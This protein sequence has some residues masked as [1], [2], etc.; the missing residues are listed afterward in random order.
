MFETID[1][2]PGH[3]IFS[4]HFWIVQSLFLI[5]T[6][7][8]DIGKRPGLKVAGLFNYSILRALSFRQ[9]EEF[10]IEHFLNFSAKGWNGSDVTKLWPVKLF[11]NRHVH[12]FSADFWI[13]C[14]GTYFFFE[15]ILKYP[16]DWFVFKKE[17]RVGDEL[18]K[19][20]WFK[21]FSDETQFWEF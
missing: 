2:D 21:K 1:G 14:R 5:A 7:I 19:I 11:I 8:T 3:R 13:I 6:R 20:F 18:P 17:K 10:K 16:I 15:E 9:K 4:F 12:P